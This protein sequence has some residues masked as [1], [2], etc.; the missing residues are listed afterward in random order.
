MVDKLN[1]VIQFD[2]HIKSSHAHQ[3]V[4]K[5]QPVWQI[6]ILRCLLN[7]T[8]T[9]SEKSSSVKDDLF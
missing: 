2:Y 4:P 7:S 8:V 1:P 5:E 3:L 6:K 9:Y